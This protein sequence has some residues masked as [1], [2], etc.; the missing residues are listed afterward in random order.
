[1]SI[2]YFGMT[3]KKTNIVKLYTMENLNMIRAKKY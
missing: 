1:M 3:K 2:E